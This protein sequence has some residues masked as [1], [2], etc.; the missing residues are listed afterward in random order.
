MSPWLQMTPEDTLP[1]SA[2]STDFLPHLFAAIQDLKANG[3]VVNCVPKPQT[4][5]DNAFNSGAIFEV[6]QAT[7]PSTPPSTPGDTLG[8]SFYS[9]LYPPRGLWPILPPHIERAP[10]DTN[11][12]D[13]IIAQEY[14][15]HVLQAYASNGKV[16]VDELTAG[17]PVAFPSV[18]L[19]VEL[20]ISQMLLPAPPLLVFAYQSMLVRL[21]EVLGQPVARYESQSLHLV[22]LAQ[23]DLCPVVLKIVQQSSAR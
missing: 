20:L 4:H 11:E 12:M 3:W 23:C 15:M 19:L 8:D 10:E 21:V 2:D 22:P 9:P 1:V 18:S 6:P 14:Y 17:V 16:C 5:V 7:V 13:V